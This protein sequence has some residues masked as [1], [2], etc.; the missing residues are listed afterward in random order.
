MIWIV[1]AIIVVGYC[2]YKAVQHNTLV[3]ASIAAQNQA[4]AQEKQKRLTQVDLTKYTKLPAAIVQPSRLPT[5]NLTINTYSKPVGK[6]VVSLVE[7]YDNILVTCDGYSNITWA[8]YCETLFFAVAHVT[9]NLKEQLSKNE[10]AYFFVVL[11]GM[12]MFEDPNFVELRCKGPDNH[13]KSLAEESTLAIRV[14]EYFETESIK[15]TFIKALKRSTLM[16][17][18]DIKSYFEEANK[19]LGTIDFDTIL[20][21]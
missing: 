16:R 14:K 4:L 5:L 20:E 12:A 8:V 11:C 9:H 1:L 15:S 3:N 21:T 19:R 7:D 13:I 18:D 6:W 10:Q 17:E 2:I